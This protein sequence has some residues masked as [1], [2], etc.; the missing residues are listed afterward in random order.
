MYICLSYCDGWLKFFLF[1]CL[2]IE[3]LMNKHLSGQAVTVA[4]IIMSIYSNKYVKPIHVQRDVTKGK[5]LCVSK[6]HICTASS[7][8]HSQI[9][10]PLQIHD[11][12]L[13]EAIS[14]RIGLDQRDTLVRF[15]K[16]LSEDVLK[17]SARTFVNKTLTGTC[18]KAS[19]FVRDVDL[20]I[21]HTSRTYRLP[22]VSAR[23]GQERG[24]SCSTFER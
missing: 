20:R 9:H 23:L 10:G 11:S 3:R 7:I 24:K 8:Q 14:G 19:A 6:M 22:A 2:L 5:N 12:K 13:L 4:A 16:H 17:I 15:F 1:V 18:S 21:D